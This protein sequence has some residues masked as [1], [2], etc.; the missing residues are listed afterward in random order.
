VRPRRCEC[1]LFAC[2]AGLRLAVDLSSLLGVARRFI[3]IGDESRSLDAGAAPLGKA[4]RNPDGRG[5]AAFGRVLPD[6]MDIVRKIQ[7]CP[8]DDAVE[9]AALGQTLTP[10]ITIIGVTC[11]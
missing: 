10:P 6:S 11:S 9:G 5:F 7:S 2:R 3:V 8:T 1:T 4:P